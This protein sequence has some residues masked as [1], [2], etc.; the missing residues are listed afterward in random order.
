MYNGFSIE[1]KVYWNNFMNAARANNGDTA[2]LK[3]MPKPTDAEVQA[4]KKRASDRKEIFKSRKKAR[5]AKAAA[6]PNASGTVAPYSHVSPLCPD[7]SIQAL[8]TGNVSVPFKEKMMPKLHILMFKDPEDGLLPLSSIPLAQRPIGKLAICAQ[9]SSNPKEETIDESL[10]DYSYV[11]P[12]LTRIS[13][14]QTRQVQL[15]RL[16]KQRKQPA[17]TS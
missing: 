6:S 12:P 9:R 1:Q 5:K 4:F 11:E 17:Q 14:T 15:V 7:L 10:R 13:N 8:S 16:M 3:T 2:K